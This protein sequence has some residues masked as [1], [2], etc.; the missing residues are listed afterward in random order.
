MYGT[1]ISYAVFILLIQHVYM[2]SKLMQIVLIS[3]LYFIYNATRTRIRSQ[4]ATQFTVVF[5][6]FVL[7]FIRFAF[8]NNVNKKKINDGVSVDESHFLHAK[9]NGFSKR[10]HQGV[11]D[12]I[13]KL[14][15]IIAYSLKKNTWNFTFCELIR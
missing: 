5:S 7:F 3:I 1:A 9:L 8:Q 2:F 14:V 11:F 13:D 12:F 10:K 6:S 4:V 15:H